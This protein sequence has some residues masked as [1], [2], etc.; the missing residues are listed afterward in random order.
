MNSMKSSLC[1][2]QTKEFVK[3]QISDI[4]FDECVRAGLQSAI[5][6]LAMGIPSL[7]LLK[8]DPLRVSK[9]GID[10]GTQS[11]KLSLNFK[12][13]DIINMRSLI[14]KKAIYDPVNYTMLIESEA[15]KPIILQGL[16]EMNG[17]ILVLP[18]VGNGRCKISLENF[19]LVGKLKMTQ[20]LKNGSTFLVVQDLSWKF[21]TSRININFDNL[22]NGNKVLAKGFIQCKKSDPKFD[23]CLKMGLQSAVPHL[24]K[25][26]PNLGLLKMDPLRINSLLIDQGTGPVSIKLDFKNLDIY[27]MKSIIIDKIHYNTETYVLDA[28]LHPEKSIVLDSDYEISG[29]VLILPIVGKGKCKIILDVAKLVATVQLKPVI[30]NGNKHLEVVK[31]AWKFTPTKLNLK[32]ENLFNGDKALGDNMSV[33]LNENWREVL[34]ELQP[35]IEEVFGTAFKEIT[36]NFLNRIPENQVLLD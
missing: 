14:I 12:D 11:I 26:V 31:I 27:N 13:L 7:G 36:Q 15:Q 30:K 4:A 18:I 6:Q 33:F 3:C 25:G 32:F 16:Y 2:V 23:E 9:L 17:Q 8:M 19:K 20:A 34:N 29:K 1:R 5:P 24:A 10:Q 28:Q 21:T 22:F 35:A